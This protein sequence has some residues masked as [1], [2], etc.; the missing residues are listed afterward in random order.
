MECIYQLRCAD[1]NR[2]ALCSDVMAAGI[3]GLKNILALTGD[4]VSLGDAPKAK[5]VYDLDSTT[6]T[7]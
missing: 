2:L 7:E 4:Y 3:L 5:P 1:R 6:L